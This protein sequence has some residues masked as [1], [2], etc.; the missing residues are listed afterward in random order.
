[1]V[2]KF[3]KIMIAMT[4]VIAVV[5]CGV[6]A[7]IIYDRV[8]PTKQEQ[9]AKACTAH[10]DECETMRIVHASTEAVKREAEKYGP[11]MAGV[12]GNLQQTQNEYD[13]RFIAEGYY[14][15]ERKSK[16]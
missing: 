11:G 9:L 14:G 3:Q 13:D 4:A 6:A 12:I 16:P 1:M 8:T 2:A 5:L 10:P 7:L 15:D